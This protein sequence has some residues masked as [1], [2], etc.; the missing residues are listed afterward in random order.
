MKEQNLND[1][2][3]KIVKVI[4]S[5]YTKEHFIQC[6]RLIEL[7]EIKWQKFSPYISVLYL[8]ESL[9]KTS[10]PFNII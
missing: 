2:Y 10:S 6:K 3:T 9:K 4:Q 1:D 7:F 8:Y 5:S